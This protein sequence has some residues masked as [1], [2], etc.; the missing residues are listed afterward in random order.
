[1]LCVI[2]FCAKDAKAALNLVHW[3]G[4]LG[5]MPNHSV[6][7]VADAGLSYTLISEIQQEA[8]K[9]FAGVKV[10][11][12]EKRDMRGH[13]RAA[14]GMFRHAISQVQSPFWWNEP[15]CIP[16]RTGWLDALEEEYSRASKPFMG[17]IVRQPL[18]HL[19]GCAVYPP[20]PA[21]YNP[22]LITDLSFAWDA[23]MPEK[24]L[25]H[26]HHTKLYCHLWS[27][28]GGTVPSFPNAA[29]LKRIPKEAAVLHRNKS[30]DLID[31]LREQH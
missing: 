17:C 12:L 9:V 14:N 24:T 15:D 7:L 11:Q 29:S 22:S 27:E 26:T 10:S 31:R 3:I 21:Q 8:K 1:M 13:P 6:L 4:E 2:P 20:N 30:H 25:R 28:P 16:L 5:A 18:V 23:V 19:T